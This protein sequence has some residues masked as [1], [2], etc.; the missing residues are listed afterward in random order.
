MCS[1]F[2][3]I[4]HVDMDCFFAAV[5]IRNNP[6]LNG[7]PVAVGNSSSQRGV[8]STCNYEARKYGCKS[9]MPVAYA[10]R[11]CPNLKLVQSSMDL[12]KKESQKIFAI[13][14]RYSNIIEGISLDEAFID[15]TDSPHFSGSATLIANAIRNDIATE[16]GLTASAGISTNKFIAKVASDIN[17]PNGYLLVKPNCERQFIAEQN[18][19]CIWGVGKVLKK[20]L[21]SDGIFKCSDFYSYSKIQL[22]QKYGQIGVRLFEFSRGLDNRIVNTN[23]QIKSISTETTFAQDIKDENKGVEQLKIIF[24]TLKKRIFLKSSQIK[25]KGH[26]KSVFCKLKFNDFSITSKEQAFETLSF[27]TF[28]NLFRNAKKRSPLPIRLIG[29][30]VRLNAKNTVQFDLF[31]D[32]FLS[33]DSQGNP[34][35]FF[36]E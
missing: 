16:L 5:E 9:A 1:I 20:K 7:H 31:D 28:E 23:R 35:G 26:F 25:N 17:K 6:S 22:A 29:I 27:P 19:S 15:V 30:G 10:L 21:E 13:F 18:V 11:L 36:W 8:L 4:I 2:R 24:E 12:Y 32:P 3:K 33:K 14:A 34:L